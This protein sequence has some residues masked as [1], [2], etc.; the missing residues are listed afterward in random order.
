MSIEIPGLNTKSGL[1]LCDDNMDI[2]LRSLRLYVS[3]IPA[4]LEKMRNVTEKTLHDYAINVHGVKGSSEYIGAEEA[5]KTA[6]ELEA[7]AKGGDLAG[8]QARN[9]AFIKY[10]ENIVSGIQNWLKKNDPSGA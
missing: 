6:K 4:T 8:V 10:V 9:D 3:N 5:R 7:M 2:Y 1:E